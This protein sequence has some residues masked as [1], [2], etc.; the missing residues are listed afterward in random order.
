MLLVTHLL[1]VDGYRKK[2]RKPFVL[3]GPRLRFPSNIS[4]FIA[5]RQ[6]RGRGGVLPFFLLGV[7]GSCEREI[8]SLHRLKI[9]CA[10][11]ERNYTQTME[12]DLVATQLAREFRRERRVLQTAL[13]GMTPELADTPWRVG[14]WTREQK[15]ANI[16]LF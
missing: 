7:A 10:L 11:R 15:F 4:F 1:S 3:T 16:A 12:G 9:H 2:M 14:G 6:K 5:I 8:C 13:L